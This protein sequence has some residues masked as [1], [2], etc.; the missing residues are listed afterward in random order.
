MKLGLRLCLSA[1]LMCFCLA[2]TVVLAGPAFN[3]LTEQDFEDVSK[4]FSANFMHHSVQ[5]AG[6]LGNIFGFEIGLVG[7][8][9]ASPKISD[10]MKRSGGSDFSNLYHAGILGA[11]LVPLG[12][13]G[14]IM[15]LPKLSSN[16]SDFQSMSAAVKLTMS[17]SLL[18]IPFN[19][20]V[21]G[22]YSS[23]VFGFK[24]DNSGTSVAVENQT[25]VTGLQLL[26]S[27]K[28]PLIE[29]YAGIG[30]V[31]AK[32]TLSANGGT[33]FSPTYTNSQSM[34]KSLTSTQILLGI[35]ANLLLFHIG[36]EY[37]N[38][39]GASSY[40]AKLAFGF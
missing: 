3:S 20:A 18:V 26:V 24:Q 36:A 33:L 7:G 11:V 6:T 12:I 27:P 39:F 23:T 37:S 30:L 8:Q 34:E 28:L 4:E 13:T 14:E 16:E 9:Q 25:K 1:V 29:P 31:S 21:R 38:A 40:T 32:N 5:G 15:I 10:V 17:E 19:L 35:T 22:F 2:P